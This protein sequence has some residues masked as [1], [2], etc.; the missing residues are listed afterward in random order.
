MKRRT[1]AIAVGLVFG[2]ALPANAQIIKG[3][4]LVRG[5]EMS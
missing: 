5:A 4:L 1:W 3:S 2:V